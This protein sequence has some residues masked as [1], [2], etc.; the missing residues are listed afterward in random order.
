MTSQI[1]YSAINITYP[2]AGVDNN[3][4]GFRDNFAAIQSALAEAYT[5][6]SLLQTNGLDVTQ[7]QNNLQG[8]IFTNG[9]YSQFN[10]VFYNAGTIGSGGVLI[11]VDNGPIQQVTMSA[12]ST[13]T[14]ENWPDAG[15]YSLIRLMLIGNQSSTYIATLTTTNSGVLK[16][17]TGWTD[18]V[19]PVTVTVGNTGKYEM[20]E[21]WTVD[22]GATVFVKNIG[23]Y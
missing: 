2:V 11:N 9:R 22:G 6:I 13:L 3:S 7:S 1:N 12:S 20:I 8:T 21:A 18:G 4:Q 10:G 19:S 17:P 14:F 5:E 15:Q 16:T 23:E